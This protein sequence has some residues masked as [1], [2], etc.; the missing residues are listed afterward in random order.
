MTKER[1]EEPLECKLCLGSGEVHVAD[2]GDMPCP[3]CSARDVARRAAAYIAEIERLRARVAELEEAQ[4]L[5]PREIIDRMQEALEEIY[6][7]PL[8]AG[9]EAATYLGYAIGV[10]RGG[11]GNRWQR[12]REAR[13]G[14]P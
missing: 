4:C 12:A 9:P 8:V 2:T 11:L 3:E 14:K 5:M 10:A 13:G 6:D 7:L 1:R